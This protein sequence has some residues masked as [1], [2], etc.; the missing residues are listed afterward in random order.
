MTAPEASPRE[1]MSMAKEPEVSYVTEN[2]RIAPRPSLLGRLRGLLRGG[3]AAS[4]PEAGRNGGSSAGG[5]QGQAPGV[6]E[7]VNRMIRDGRHAML[8]DRDLAE[9]VGDAYVSGAWKALEGHMALIPGGVLPVTMQDSSC[10]F[11]E[12]GAFY[13]DRTAVTNDEFYRFV[14]AGCYEDL[15]IWPQD[16]WPALTTRFLDRT[17]HAGPADWENGRPPSGKGDHPVTGVSWFEAAAFAQWI[18]KRLPTAAEWQKAGGFPEQL[19]SHSHGTRYPW[20]DL[21]AEGKANLYHGR[22]GATVPVKE[23]KAGATP[24]GI[25]QM[26]GNV[27]EW[28]DDRLET[29]P[30]EA[31][32]TFLT[33][34]PMR[35]IV[36]GAYDTYLIHEAA[37]DF[38]TGQQ[39][40]DRR[41]NIGFRCAVP[42]E[43]LRPLPGVQG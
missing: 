1:P 39:E 27:W 9:T 18:G 15:D 11:V 43:K 3:G 2:G 23:Y 16:I 28:L 38:V 7:H 24:N 31:G 40:L 8:L 26:S 12:V 41:P 42:L 25:Y 29:I 6:M 21:Y 35:R 13:L 5:A 36:G 30:R 32:E 20:G 17:R 4:G 10:Q 14:S 22:A 33:S 19:A 37:N 34:H